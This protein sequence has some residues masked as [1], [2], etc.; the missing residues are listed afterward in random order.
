MTSISHDRKFISA[1]I[2]SARFSVMEVNSDSISISFPSVNFHLAGQTIAYFIHF[3][4]TF[5]IIP[6]IYLAK[7]RLSF[8]SLFLCV[9]VREHVH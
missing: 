6:C 1:V 5:P 3:F 8:L 9:R 2:I 4:F 7:C